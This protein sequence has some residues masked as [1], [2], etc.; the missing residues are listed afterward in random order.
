MDVNLTEHFPILIRCPSC[1]QR[2]RVSDE[3]IGRPV[4]C[5]ACENRFRIAPD[6]IIRGKKFYPGERTVGSLSSFQRVPLPNAP[7]PLGFNSISYDDVPDLLVLEPLS[8][9]RIIAG[10]FGVLVILFTVMLLV[11]GASHGGVLDGMTTQNRIL[12]AVFN[13]ILG[14]LLLAYANPRLH[15][16][17]LVFGSVLLGLLISLPLIFK[18]GAKPLGEGLALKVIQVEDAKKPDESFDLV[19]LRNQIGTEPLEE[20][21]ARLQS[22][23]SSRQAVG[24]WLRN[25]REQNRFLI[26]DYILRATRADPQSHY[27]PRGEGNFLMVVTGISMPIDEVAELCKQIG[28]IQVVYSALPVIEVKVRNENFVEKP[29]EGLSNKS[30]PDFYELNLSELQSIDLIRVE[31]AVKRLM[32]ASPKVLRA[33]ITAKMIE[34]LSVEE[35][36]FKPDICVALAVWSEQPGPAGSV[37]LKEIDKLLARGLDVPK[38]MVALTVKEG[39]VAVVPALDALWDKSPSAWESLYADVGPAAELPML[40]HVNSTDEGKRRSV[41]RVLGKVGGAESIKALETMKVG[42]EPELHILIDGSMASIR[43][44]IGR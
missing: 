30:A 36:T 9:Q 39:I 41:V 40:Q 16:K 44:R 25:L 23:G 24:L 34:L 12:M 35:I 27:Y 14:M 43:E 26:R 3:L 2:F 17:L 21:I 22:E 18:E 38:E 19:Q 20:E 13:G 28:E 1:H 10:V 5:G 31:K 33:D 8:P 42:A 37:A 4:E 11:F 32:D 15:R 7:G 29:I 6:V